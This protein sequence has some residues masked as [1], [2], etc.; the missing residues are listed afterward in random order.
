VVFG[1][2]TIIIGSNGNVTTIG[3]FEEVETNSSVVSN[4]W[5]LQEQ[6]SAL[7]QTQL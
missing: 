2:K 7:F 5:T 1:V 3:I 6:E 4:L